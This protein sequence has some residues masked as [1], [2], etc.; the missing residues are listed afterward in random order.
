MRSF[1]KYSVTSIAGVMLTL[2]V[3]GCDTHPQEVA[4]GANL[5]AE[6]N[7]EVAWTAPDRGK[8]FVYDQ[9]NHQLIWSGNVH[10]GDMLKIERPSNRLT[11]KGEPVATRLAPYHNEQ[12]Y[13]EPRGSSDVTS[14]DQV[15]TSE[16]ASPTTQ[17]SYGR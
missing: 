6:G 13:F 8:A 12:I 5:T 17:P 1:A 11:L 2:G 15:Y 10:K 9:N 16:T 4:P 14:S 7:Q 3:L